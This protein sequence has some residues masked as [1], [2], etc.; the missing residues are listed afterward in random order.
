MTLYRYIPVW[1]REP[2]T[3]KLYRCFEILGDGG[4]VVQN[5]DSFTPETYRER[6]AQM[7]R[8]FV[9]L[10]LEQCPEKRITPRPSIEEAIRYFESL[11]TQESGS[12]ALDAAPLL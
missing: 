11:F 5:A 3:A 9:E 10:L 4:Y 8:Q 7:D 12:Q 2:R 1:R 6:D